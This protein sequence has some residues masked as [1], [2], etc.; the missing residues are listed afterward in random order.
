MFDRTFDDYDGNHHYGDDNLGYDDIGPRF[1]VPGTGGFE[2]R[3]RF[4]PFGPPGGP[5]EPGRSG[6]GR[7]GGRGGRGGG[8]G[9][10]GLPGGLGF[11]NPDHLRPPNN[12]YF[13]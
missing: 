11:P 1:R 12:D 13:S 2:M 4:D 5:T 9:S 6:R 7:G 8:R 10:G 3:P